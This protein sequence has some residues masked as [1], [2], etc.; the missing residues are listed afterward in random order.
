M[1]MNDQGTLIHQDPNV[2][3]IVPVG[4]A[5]RELGCSMTW[6]EDECVFIHPVK[7]RLHVEVSNGCPEIS[8]H[9]ALDIT[10]DLEGP[11]KP[12]AFRGV[13]TSD[14]RG[15]YLWLDRLTREHPIFKNVPDDVKDKILETP[16]T[17]LDKLGL[18]RRLRKRIKNRGAI[19]HLYTLARAL[20][21]AGGG[22][23][24]LIEIDVLRDEGHDLL[25]QGGIEWRSTE[26]WMRWEE[27]QH[28]IGSQAYPK[29]GVRGP[30]ANVE[31][32]L[33]APYPQPTGV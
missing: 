33:G 16:D 13:K 27:L 7:G 1:H 3:P 9:D 29:G 28:P 6:E 25:R 31:A 11:R 19:L 14:A 22:P 24:T 4:R 32:P 15:D 8:R 30:I 21:G 12:E 10:E 18:N 20:K 2:D 17:H 26:I 23:T 5:I